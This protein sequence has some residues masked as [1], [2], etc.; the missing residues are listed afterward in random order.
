MIWDKVFWIFFAVSGFL[1]VY[2]LFMDL[3]VTGILLSMILICTGFCKL[4]QES[5]R[6]RKLSKRIIDRLKRGL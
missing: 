2:A 5:G 4:S 3:S 1:A 6:E